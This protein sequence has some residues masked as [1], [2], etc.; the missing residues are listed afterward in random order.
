MFLLLFLFVFDR[1]STPIPHEKQ[2]PL[3]RHGPYFALLTVVE[4]TSVAGWVLVT[5]LR[6]FT[7]CQPINASLGAYRATEIERQA[8]ALDTRGQSNG[9]P[10][11]CIS[12]RARRSLSGRQGRKQ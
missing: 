1:S 9:S 10:P 5:R 8:L 6:D 3:G 2:A 4:K 12:H 7:I 11:P